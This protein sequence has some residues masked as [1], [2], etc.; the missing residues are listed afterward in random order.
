M[1]GSIGERRI[2]IN[3]LKSDALPQQGSTLGVLLMDNF[4][5]RL[6]F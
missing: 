4:T 6:F 1:K 3:G 5:G 2:T